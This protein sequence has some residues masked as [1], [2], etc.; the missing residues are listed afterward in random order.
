MFAFL[1]RLV[2]FVFL[3]GSIAFR[4]EVARCGEPGAAPERKDS[5]VVMPLRS[6]VIKKSALDALNQLLPVT[7]AEV[8]PLEVVTKA[9]IDA[10]LD[11][12]KIKDALACDDAHCAAQIAGALGARYLVTGT[13]NQ[14]GANI[15]VVL[16]LIDT[17]L[18][19]T[20]RGQA[21]GANDEASFDQLIERAARDVLKK[22]GISAVTQ[23]NAEA[24]A[25]P[26]TG[27][28]LGSRCEISLPKEGCPSA[29]TLSAVFDDDWEHAGSDEGR[30]LRR[31]QEYFDYC[32]SSAPVIARF[33]E[34]TKVKREER[35][36][37]KTRCEIRFTDERC[38]ALPTET[39]MRW[40]D[41]AENASSDDVRCMRR[42][43]EYSDYCASSAPVIARFYDGTKLKREERAERKTRC[44]IR[45]TDERC[46]S[47][48]ADPRIRWNDD[49]E[50]AS[51]DDVRC[52]RRAIEYFDYC[53]SSTL[54]VAR[55][56]EGAKVKR[57]QRAERKTRC[58]LR[59]TD[60]R[61]PALPAE[62]RTHWNDILE[63]AHSDESRCMARALE[64]YDACGSGAAVI[65]RF[66]EVTKL[67]REERAER[68]T[69]CEISFTEERCPAL[70]AD[71]RI[72]WNDDWEH[73]SS[74]RDRCM[75]RAAEWKSY[76]K[77]QRQVTARFYSGATIVEETT[78]R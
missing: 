49:W 16:N 20:A 71:T 56:Y 48:S 18:Q 31:A 52:M 74:D 25:P 7:L 76:C 33:Y 73:A 37:R 4:S 70:R 2:G 46:P 11:H 19:K 17:T 40:N 42:A 13:V 57:E 21:K 32:A 41:D 54:V 10:Q 69:R 68:K 38:P 27:P 23:P 65:A 36:E 72:R 64:W 47:L 55:F 34:G 77:S 58:E 51:S 24:S 29:S 53:G 5:V 60:E 6:D 15:I 66:Y 75:R 22:A 26:T 28:A 59:F 43:Q 3:V 8:S 63:E 14:L 30:C 50:H 61:C 35:A 62:T 45:F 78:A 9:D 12:E 44:E 1:A 39:R 67:K